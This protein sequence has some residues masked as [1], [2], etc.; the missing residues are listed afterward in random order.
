MITPSP[1]ISDYQFPQHWVL[2]RG[3][4]AHVG[5]GAATNHIRGPCRELWCVLLFGI[6]SYTPC[7]EGLEGAAQCNDRVLEGGGG[8]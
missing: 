6:I 2:P 5:V 8:L 3:L 4:F 1:F 7:P